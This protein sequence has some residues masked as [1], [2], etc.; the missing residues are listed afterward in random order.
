[1]RM[2]E[3]QTDILTMKQKGEVII[4]TDANAWIG[5]QPSIIEISDSNSR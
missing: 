3:L 2:Q 4:L 1:M 5:E